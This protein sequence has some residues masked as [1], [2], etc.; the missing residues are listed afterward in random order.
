[1]TEALSAA[2]QAREGTPPMPVTPAV[3]A[4]TSETFDL[5]SATGSVTASAQTPFQAFQLSRQQ[6]GSMPVPSA[7]V[8][9]PL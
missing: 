7:D 6:P 9:V 1:M 2:L 3:V 8:V 4:V 5:V